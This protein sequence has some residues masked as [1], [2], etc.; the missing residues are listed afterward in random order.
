M[1][2]IS[3]HGELFGFHEAGFSPSSVAASRNF[4]IAAVVL[5]TLALVVRFAPRS[6][7]RRW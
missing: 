7:Q 1:L 2:L 5:L 3:E 4:E 6:A